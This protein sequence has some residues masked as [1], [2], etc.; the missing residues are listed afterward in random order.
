MLLLSLSTPDAKNSFQ[1]HR[2]WTSG[3]PGSQ[4]FLIESRQRTGYDTSVPSD[5]PLIRHVDENQPD[6]ADESHYM[7]GLVQADKR[8]DLKWAATPRLLHRK[9]REPLVQSDQHSQFELAHR[10]A[11]TLC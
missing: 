5:E 8:Q 9:H 4:Y 3:M 11:G 6:N 10:H 2:L 1:V 7:T